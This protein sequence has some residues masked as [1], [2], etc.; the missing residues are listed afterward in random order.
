MTQNACPGK[1][2]QE[3]KEGRDC[4]PGI[5]NYAKPVK[6]ITTKEKGK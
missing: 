4:P 2:E 1:C 5:C 3:L 6:V